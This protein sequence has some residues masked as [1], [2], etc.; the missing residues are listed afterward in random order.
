MQARAEGASQ[1]ERP[2]TVRLQEAQAD[3][4][5]RGRSATLDAGAQGA[6]HGFRVA[7]AKENQVDQ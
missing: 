4:L 2:C 6:L 5:G 7:L 3:G 1:A